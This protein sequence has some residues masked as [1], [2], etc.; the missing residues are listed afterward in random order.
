[1]RKETTGDTQGLRVRSKDTVPHCII[2][3]RDLFLS[4][5]RLINEISN[6]KGQ[7]IQYGKTLGLVAFNI[8][9]FMLVL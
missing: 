6:L 3:C 9:A 4:G 2:F 7:H 1:M 5:Y 8:N